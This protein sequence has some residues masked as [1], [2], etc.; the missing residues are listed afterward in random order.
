MIWVVFAVMTGVAVL[1][2]LWP[3]AGKPRDLARAEIEANLYRQEIAGIDRDVDRGLM[4]PAD[5]ADARAEA[6][7]RLLAVSAAE[8]KPTV[9]RRGVRIAALLAILFIPGVTLGLYLTLGAPDYPDRPLQARLQA[10][11]AQMDIEAAVAKVEAHLAE[12]PDDARGWE[13]VANV[14]TRLGRAAEAANAYRQL[15]R[16]QGPS[17]DLMLSYAQALIYAADGKVT[18]EAVA[19]SE[20]VLRDEPD[21]PQAKFFIGISQE[22]RGDTAAAIATFSTLLASAPPDAPWAGMVRE[23]I[24][25][26]GGK[27][28]AV[29]APPEGSPGAAIAALPPGERDTVIRGM[30]EGLAARL[31]AGGG[32]AEEWS[33]LVRAYTVLREPDKAREA[34]ASARKALATDA[35]ANGQLEALARELGLGG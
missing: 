18:E 3:L 26:L 2:F 34:L 16:L 29:N 30:V 4:T 24:E 22:Q 19:A 1:A 14:Y 6:A 13:I 5:A 15:I 31:S 7:R 32:T 33:R 10:P 17:P 12:E 28:P 35:A 8:Q 11:P 23:R 25:S 20:Q 21:N 27:A 9:S